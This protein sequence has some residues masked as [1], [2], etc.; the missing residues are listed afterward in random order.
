[1]LQTVQIGRFR[2]HELL[3]QFA[4]EK[5]TANSAPAVTTLRNHAA[6]YLNFLRQ[7]TARLLSHEQR[8]ALLTIDHEIHNVRAA[9]Q[10]AVT[11]GMTT[12]I[13]DAVDGL[14]DY[15]CTRGHFQE[16]CDCFGLAA[17]QFRSSLESGE[18]LLLSRLYSRQAQFHRWM[19]RAADAEALIPLLSVGATNKRE[20]AFVLNLRGNIANTLHKD[21]AQSESS[22][23]QSLELYRELG[24]QYGQ[25]RLLLHLGSLYNQYGS[26]DDALKLL[27]DA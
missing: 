25:A 27:T 8:Q 14:F 2:M 19:G 12:E 22:L 18:S 13:D 17:S 4:E 3:R 10:R 23:R 16:G 7:Q 20:A 21:R 9:W 11:Q 24:D 15:Y 5:L 26:T 6:H 1:M